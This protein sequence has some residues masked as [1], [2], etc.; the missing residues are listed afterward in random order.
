MCVHV[1]VYVVG[2]ER[3]VRVKRKNAFLNMAAA[4]PVAV[5]STPDCTMLLIVPLIREP[6]TNC[7]LNQRASYLLSPYAES[8]LLSY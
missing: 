6:V 4:A 7:P 2:C 8:Q 1:R 3:E 5:A